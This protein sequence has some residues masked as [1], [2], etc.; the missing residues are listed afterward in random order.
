[1]HG[2][3]IPPSTPSEKS[4]PAPYQL[5]AEKPIILPNQHSSKQNTHITKQLQTTNSSPSTTTNQTQPTQHTLTQ[6][7]TTNQDSTSQTSYPINTR[8]NT[9]DPTVQTHPTIRPILQDPPPI[10]LQTRPPLL[11]TPPQH[12]RGP[13]VYN[14]YQ[15][16]YQQVQSLIALPTTTQIPCPQHLRNLSP[17]SQHQNYPNQQQHTRFNYTNPQPSFHSTATNVRWQQQSHH[18]PHRFTPPQ[19]SHTSNATNLPPQQPTQ[20]APPPPTNTYTTSQNT[21]Q[22]HSSHTSQKD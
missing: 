18:T 5:L 6:P 10:R 21:P 1:M 19:L 22:T 3:L 7:S 8:P 16:Q 4:H 20:K 13:I 9:S 12:L 17:Q 14:T 2:I 11:P 15:G